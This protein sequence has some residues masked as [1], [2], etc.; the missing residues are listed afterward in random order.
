VIF[1]HARISLNTRSSS[2]ACL[3]WSIRQNICSA[4]WLVF[5]ADARS[6]SAGAERN[7][8]VATRFDKLA[9]RYEATVRIAAIGEWLSPDFLNMP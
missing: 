4:P 3:P 7:R 2:W 9:V 8:A 6:W 1:D 5:P